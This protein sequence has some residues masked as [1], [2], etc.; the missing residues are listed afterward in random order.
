MRP[1][2]WIRKPI[3]I[4]MLCLAWGMAG[5]VARAE[6]EANKFLGVEI[7]HGRARYVVTKDVNV[8]LGPKTSAK[9]IDSLERGARIDGAG[10][11]QADKGWVAVLRDGEP[12]GF[13]Y[14]EMLLRLIDGTLTDRPA[15]E[16]DGPN[17]MSC[18]YRIRFDGKAP[19]EDDLFEVA[20]YTVKF[21]CGNDDTVLRF[22]TPLFLTEAPYRLGTKPEYQISLDVVEISDGYD[23]VFSATSIYDGDKKTVRF[24]STTIAAY[25][26]NQDK[27]PR[28]VS[29]VP[30]A[31][32]TAVELAVGAWN[33]K[34]WAVLKKQQH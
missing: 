33:D 18:A 7:E 31:L 30:E 6:G 34:V 10:R 1:M 26:A 3:S 8:R 9:K 12:L 25:T 23:Q 11:A 5:D 17:G 13:V 19:V 20:D 28:P 22:S 27:T 15:G 4:L 24:D 2:A 14:G 16:V 32:T 29:G 21:R